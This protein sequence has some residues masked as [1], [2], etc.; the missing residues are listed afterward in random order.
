[1]HQKIIEKHE[2]K[3]YNDQR[4]IKSLRKKSNYK[5]KFT[6]SCKQ[7]DGIRKLLVI[8]KVFDEV[9]KPGIR[10]INKIC[11]MLIHQDSAHLLS[12]E[13]TSS[14]DL[15]NGSREKNEQKKIPHRL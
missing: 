10:L 2:S 6:Q 1:M 11:C 5:N 12:I 14:P 8:D 4:S 7:I 3:E 9:G 15:P 13:N